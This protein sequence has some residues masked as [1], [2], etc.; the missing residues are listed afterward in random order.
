MTVTTE[1]E[2]RIERLARLGVT[3]DMIRQHGLASR[4]AQGL[5]DHI[6]DP[7]VLDRIVSLLRSN[8]GRAT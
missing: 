5:P 7:A 6:E 8:R 1:H 2:R 4:R 3:P